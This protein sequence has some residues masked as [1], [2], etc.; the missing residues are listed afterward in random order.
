MGHQSEGLGDVGL[1]ILPW[2][3]VSAVMKEVAWYC[4]YH[5]LPISKCISYI[6]FRQKVN[7]YVILYPVLMTILHIYSNQTSAATNKKVNKL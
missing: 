5:G 7:S 4:R 2:G 1:P 6:I 3:Q